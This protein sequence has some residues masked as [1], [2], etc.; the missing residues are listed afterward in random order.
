MR[1][2]DSNMHGGNVT[3][4]SHE[5]HR[6]SMMDEQHDVVATVTSEWLPL[7]DVWPAESH[8]VLESMLLVPFSSLSIEDRSSLKT[9]CEQIK[10]KYS[11]HQ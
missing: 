5:G 10:Q 1:P 2:D 9:V 7:P 11:L 8:R 4:H 3:E 6:V